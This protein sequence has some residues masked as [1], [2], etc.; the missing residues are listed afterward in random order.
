MNTLV[1]STKNEGKLREFKQ[2]LGKLPYRILSLADFLGIG[3]IE[4]GRSF[5]E[6]ALIKAK[7]VAQNTGFI[8]LG[9]DSGLEVEALGGKPGIYTARYAG[10]GARDEDNIRKLL[11]EME[12]VP[13]EKRRARFVCS[14]ALVFPEGKIFIERGFCKGI[15][16]TK[17]GG[18]HG[19]G[20]D[21]VF[22]LPEYGKTMAEL[23]DRDK[24]RISHR[25]RAVEKIKKHLMGEEQVYE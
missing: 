20:Y 12:N 25:A 23:P 22:Y 1:I 11:S 6:N 15:I 21:P 19:F 13:W 10:E 17:P 2:M 16:A 8:A 3:I 7:A 18:E 4:N 5:D 9:D 14:L 24:N